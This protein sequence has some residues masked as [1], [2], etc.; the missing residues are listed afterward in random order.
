MNLAVNS[1]GAISWSTNHSFVLASSPSVGKRPIS[2][3]TADVNGDGKV[4][5]ICANSTDNTLSVLTNNGSGSFGSNATLNVGFAPTC[6][7]AVDVNNDGKVDLVCANSG[8]ATISVLTNKGNGSFATSGTYGAGMP[9]SGPYSVVAADVNGDGSVDLISANWGTNNTLTI[10]TNNGNGGFG[11]NATLGTLDS[12]KS[13]A[14]GDFNADGKI[15]LVCANTGY[16]GS[17]SSSLTVFTNDGSGN[18]SV[19]SKPSLLQYSPVSVT[20][21]DVNGD[22][23]LDLISANSFN[24]QNTLT[25]LTNNGNG[26]FV[27]ASTLVVSAGVNTV[28][29]TDI[30]GDGKLDLICANASDNT[31]SLWLNVSGGNFIF[32]STLSVGRAPQSVVATDVNGDGQMDLISANGNDNTLSILTNSESQTPTANY[33][34]NGAN[35]VNLSANAITGALTTNV[36]IGTLTFYYT[37]GILRAIK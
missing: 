3:T 11:Y 15:D 7:I 14:A 4:D 6:V 9:N 20:V 24:S 32:S 34:G 27:L 25:V 33:S 17:A 35:L 12:P 37:N 1:A 28:I 16:G 19:S 2:V 10:L 29:A 30:N 31:L 13:V 5:L 36:V 18:F 8:S 26:G 21:A 22:G 23:K